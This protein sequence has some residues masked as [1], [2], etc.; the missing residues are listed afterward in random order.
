MIATITVPGSI[1]RDAED[2]TTTVNGKTVNA[3]PVR[4]RGLERDDAEYVARSGLSRHV[5][6]Y[7]AEA[8]V[9]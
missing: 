6:A 1:P 2:P 4:A 8:P 7:G 9:S 5:G 3:S